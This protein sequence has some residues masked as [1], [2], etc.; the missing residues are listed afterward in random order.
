MLDTLKPVWKQFEETYQDLRYAL[1]AVSDDDLTWSPGGEARS[2]AGLIQHIAS[3]NFLYMRILEGD[4]REHT[5]EFQDAPTRTWLE[6]RLDESERDVQ[7]VFDAITAGSLA[8][9]RADDWSPLSDVNLVVG[10]LDGLW[11]ALQAVRHTAYHLGQL[12]VYLLMRTAR[13]AE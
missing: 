13:R 10:P 6:E 3:A 5:W 7:E 2:V 8:Y 11:F 12:N 4:M 1:A 9:P